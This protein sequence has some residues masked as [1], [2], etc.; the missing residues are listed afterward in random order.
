MIFR[1]NVL[2]AVY[3]VNETDCTAKQV[4]HLVVGTVEILHVYRLQADLNNRQTT[5]VLKSLYNFP[6]SHVARM[7]TILSSKLKL[8]QL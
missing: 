1:R 7:I 2:Q 4:T 8:S 3:K 6:I 5:S